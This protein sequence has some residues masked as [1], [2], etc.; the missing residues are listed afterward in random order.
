MNE[1]ILILDLETER[2]LDVNDRMCEI[3]GYTRE[4]AFDRRLDDLSA[5]NS[6]YTM[7]NALTCIGKAAAEG[8]QCLEW[9]ARDHKGRLFWI[10]VNIRHALINE[11]ECL[12]L[13]IRDIEERKQA[14][15]ALERER[16]RFLALTEEAPFGIMLLNKES[17][18]TYI[19]AKFREVFGYDLQDIPDGKTWF[20]RAYPDT[21]YRHMAIETW[22]KDVARFSQDPSL[23]E[24]RLWTFN[25]TCKDNRQR[26]VNFITVQL[27]TSEYLVT[28]EDITESKMAEEE[29]K[30]REIELDAKSKNLEEVNAALRVLLKERENDKVGLEEKIL[31]NVRELIIPYVEKLK[32][33]RLDPSHMTYLGIIETNLNDIISPFLQKMGL[34][35]ARLTPTEIEI[36]NLIKN[37]KRTKEIGEIL[38]MSQGAINFHR[39]NIRRKLGLNNEKINLRSYLLSI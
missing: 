11:Q 5:G 6:P 20:R 8:P 3:Y 1:A 25:V 30:K 24:S 21:T 35:Y 17:R 23:R 9:R 7:Q 12:L 29:L 36:A 27:P 22:L 10:E 16:R 34:K 39:N 32:K 28:L 33:C 13:T 37:G 19:N 31:S 38:H 14:G 15:E 18:F 4:E 26:V 2:I